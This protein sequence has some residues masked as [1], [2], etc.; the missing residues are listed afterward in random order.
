[1]KKVFYNSRIAKLILFSSY[2]TI[3]LCAWVLTVCT[4]LPQEVINHECTHARQWIE[5]T[6]LSGVILWVGLLLFGYSAWWLALSAAIFYLWYGLE[7]AVR[8]IISKVFI[9]KDNS[10][11]DVYRQV[12]F[13]Q[14]ARLAEKDSNYLENSHYFAWRR[15]YKFKD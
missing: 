3:T 11:K 14:E 9:R 2:S 4:R 6:V 1:M 5:L 12:S 8:R 10:Q 15:F 7:Y 13:E